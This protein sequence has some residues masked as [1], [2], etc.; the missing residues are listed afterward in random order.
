MCIVYV[1]CIHNTYK[2]MEVSGYRNVKYHYHYHYHYFYNYHYQ[3]A[4]R[5]YK[6]QLLNQILFFSVV[7]I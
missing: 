2:H 4:T 1:M 5:L 7:F 6:Q 3:E